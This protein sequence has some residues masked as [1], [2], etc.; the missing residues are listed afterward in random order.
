MSFSRKILKKA[1]KFSNPLDNTTK[2]WYNTIVVKIELNG[3][4]QMR[5]KDII[6]KAMETDKITQKELAEAIGLKS[7]QA[8]G[9]LLVRENGMRLDGFLKMLDV[10]GYEVVVR[11]KLGETEEWKVEQ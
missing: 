8:I 6:K 5:A 3:G 7:Q 10:M 11:K 2:M 4:Y 9:N 1:E